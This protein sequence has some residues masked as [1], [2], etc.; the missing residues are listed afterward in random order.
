[1]KVSVTPEGRSRPSRAAAPKDMKEIDDSDEELSPLSSLIAPPS[2]MPTAIPIGDDDDKYE[3]SSTDSVTSIPATANKVS[4]VAA[5]NRE[6]SP[7]KRAFDEN[8]GGSPTKKSRKLII[9]TNKFTTVSTQAVTP[10]QAPTPKPSQAV[11]PS[12]S[13][14]DNNVADLQTL[15]QILKSIQGRVTN[16][17]QE[18]QVGLDLKEAKKK[19]ASLEQQLQMS[20]SSQNS[21]L[22]LKQCE[23]KFRRTLLS[24]INLRKENDD[25][26]KERDDLKAF[27]TELRIDIAEVLDEREQHLNDSFKITDDQADQEWRRIAFEIR[28]FVSQVCTV[29]PYRVSAPK[30]AN[31]KEV[32]ALKQNQKKCPELDRFYFQQYIWRRLARNVFQAEAGIWGGPTGQAFHRFCL[33][34]SE[35]NFKGMRELSRIKAHTADF[36]SKHSDAENNAEMKRVTLSMKNDLFIFMDSDKADGAGKRLWEIVRR[37]VALNAS[38]LKSRAFFVTSWISDEINDMDNMNIQFTRGDTSGDPEVEIEISPMLSK[39]GNADGRYFDKDTA[40]VICKPM[41]TVINV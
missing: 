20:L 40:M 37:A 2:S 35:V 8:E 12:H 32:D 19:I 33:D 3:H 5:I 38:L 24:E 41:V 39:I 6:C 17:I 9:K 1:M 26:K 21:Q 18:A 30:G 16:T 27:N 31:H 29:K 7:T 11:T 15:Q 28:N 10:V 4:D 13:A 14:S 36:L 34:L 23:E 25:L 22:E